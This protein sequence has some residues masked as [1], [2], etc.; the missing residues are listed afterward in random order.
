MT[1]S[2]C[3]CVSQARH[4]GPD[5]FVL[6]LCVCICPCCWLCWWWPL[7]SKAASYQRLCVSCPIPQTVFCCG[8]VS[9]GTCVEYQCVPGSL[10]VS[11]WNWARECV[12]AYLLDVSVVQIPLTLL[13]HSFTV[14]CFS[15]GLVS[16]LLITPVCFCRGC[17]GRVVPSL[18]SSNVSLTQKF[19][20]FKCSR[21]WMDFALI[22]RLILLE[23]SFAVSMDIS[24]GWSIALFQPLRKIHAL[25]SY[26][27]SSLI[28]LSFIPS[29]LSR[30]EMCL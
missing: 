4:R 29:F 16:C 18:N 28:W 9:S 22:S 19:V 12:S 3:V 17:F 8:A 10:G 24:W 1:V 5:T 23:Q 27:Y 14:T 11:A 6:A 26:F 13:I 30:C 25:S 20:F 7:C 2:E 21:E 15:N